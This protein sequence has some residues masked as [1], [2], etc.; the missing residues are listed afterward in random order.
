[1][2]N[3][4]VFDHELVGDLVE[5]GISYAPVQENDYEVIGYIR[6][7][8]PHFE[9]AMMMANSIVSLDPNI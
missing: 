5:M 9:D 3:Q 4:L 8:H 2:M 7:D 6:T 1:M